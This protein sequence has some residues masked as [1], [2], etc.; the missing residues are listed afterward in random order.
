MLELSDIVT[1]VALLLLG[2]RLT[3]IAPRSLLRRRSKLYGTVLSIA[4]YGAP[5]GHG[6]PLPLGGGARAC[7]PISD[8]QLRAGTAKGLSLEPDGTK[9]FRGCRLD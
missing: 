4:E 1:L 8:Y 5:A 7:P 3:V 6:L 9:G 2:L